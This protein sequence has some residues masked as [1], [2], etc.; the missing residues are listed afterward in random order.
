MW[1]GERKRETILESRRLTTACVD[2]ADTAVV[3]K[4]HTRNC[5]TGINDVSKNN[6]FLNTSQF[7]VVNNHKR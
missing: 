6:R 5:N 4:P 7:K 2:A 3:K 1:V